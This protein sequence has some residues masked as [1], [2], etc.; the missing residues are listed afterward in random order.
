MAAS[1]LPGWRAASRSDCKRSSRW[2]SS[3]LR[4]WIS[5]DWAWSSS[6]WPD[7]SSDCWESSSACW[8]SS[9]D[10]RVS[11]SFCRVNCSARSCWAMLRASVQR[12]RRRRS[13]R[14]LRK[15]PVPVKIPMAR[16]SLGA[17]MVNDPYGGMNQKSAASA[18]STVARIP[19]PPPPMLATNSTAR[20]KVMNG[21]IGPNGLA[22]SPC[23]AAATA[24]ISTA[25][26]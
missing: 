15:R 20:K 4:A 6:F 25:A 2:P 1:W 26:P 19:G 18:A 8:E 13:A 11:S 10:C 21:G 3:S 12:A 9:S 24:T 23:S 22:S 5:S 14:T 17:S 16:T 7:S